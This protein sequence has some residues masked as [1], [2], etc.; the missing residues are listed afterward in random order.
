M[1]Q[2]TRTSPG[3]ADS[4]RS[5]GGDLGERVRSL[6]LS[7]IPEGRSI[8]RPI[9]ATL[10]GL[11]VIALCAVLVVTNYSQ[12]KQQAAAPGAATGAAPAPP[13]SESANSALKPVVEPPAAASGGGPPVAKLSR[14]EIALESKGYIIPAHQILVTPKV[15]GMIVKLY[16]EEG[17][18]F[19]KGDVLAELESIDYDYDVEL[20]QAKVRQAL[21]RQKEMRDFYRPEEKQEAEANLAEAEVQRVQAEADWKRNRDLFKRGGVTD[22]QLQTSESNFHALEERVK[23]LTATLGMIR[24]GARPERKRLADRE[25]EQAQA[26]LKK[27]EWRRGN[28][29]IRAPISGTILTKKAEEGNNVNPANFNGTYSI[30]EMA[31]LS[32]LEVDLNIQERD[33]SRIHVGQYCRVRA[34][35]YKDRIYDGVVSRLMPIADR[36]KGAIPVRVKLRVPPEEEGVYLK[37]EM[38]AEVT[39][40]TAPA[41][42]NERADEEK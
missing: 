41:E 15:L 2:I 4:E 37:P 21:E 9:L 40:L 18:R 26:E 3:A 1:S 36:A 34:D 14:G 27:A 23:K 30:C 11:G 39:F 38:G 24:I 28:C 17:K 13:A 6:R 12:L 19:Q 5:R 22:Q 33:I 20:A 7:Q 29:T 32:D 31:D 35:A 16:V 8:V 10:F 42:R 25:L